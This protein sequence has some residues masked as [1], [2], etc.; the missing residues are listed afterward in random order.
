MESGSIWPRA[1]GVKDEEIEDIL[2]KLLEGCDSISGIMIY[3]SVA[4][5]YGGGFTCKLLEILDNEA[6]K[7]NKSTISLMPSDSILD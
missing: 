1:Y 3:H 4:G 5:G 2:K 6:S 7:S